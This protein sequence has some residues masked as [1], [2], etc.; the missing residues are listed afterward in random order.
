LFAGRPEPFDHGVDLLTLKPVDDLRDA[1]GLPPVFPFDEAIGKE[2]PR[3][4]TRQKQQK[5]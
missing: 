4:E 1:A 2:Q 3:A 5:Y